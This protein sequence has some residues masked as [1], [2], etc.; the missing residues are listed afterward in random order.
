MVLF[1]RFGDFASLFDHGTLV[2]EIMSHRGACRGDPVGT[3][4]SGQSG[5]RRPHDRTRVGLLAFFYQ[6]VPFSRNALPFRA[7]ETAVLP[8]RVP[9]G[10]VLGFFQQDQHFEAGGRAR[11]PEEYSREASGYLEELRTKVI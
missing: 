4:E 6:N 7:G 5:D 9:A 3:L 2:L 8:V 10:P 1:I 11:L